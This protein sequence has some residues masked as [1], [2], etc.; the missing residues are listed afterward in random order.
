[1]RADN[2][3]KEYRSFT[4]AGEIAAAIVFLASPAA[5]KMNGHRLHLHG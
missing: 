2:P 4:D 3:D 5:R 1:M